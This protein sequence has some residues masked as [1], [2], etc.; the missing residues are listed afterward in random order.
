MLYFLI[1]PT[2]YTGFH[3]YPASSECHSTFSFCFNDTAT[4]DIYTLSLH[5]ALP[6]YRGHTMIHSQSSLPYLN[7][8]EVGYRVTFKSGCSVRTRNVSF[9]VRFMPFSVSTIKHA[10]CQRFTS[11]SSSMCISIHPLHVALRWVI[12]ATQSLVP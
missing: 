8:T 11:S 7:T 1:R 3:Y 9:R 5:D 4:T 10:S 6:I 2:G 12:L